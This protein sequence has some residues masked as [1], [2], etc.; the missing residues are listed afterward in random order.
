[1][2]TINIDTFAQLTRHEQEIVKR[3]N[4]MPNGGALFLIHP[5]QALADADV[6]LSAKAKDE[7]LKI[8]PRI[9]TLSAAPYRAMKASTSKQSYRIRI[10]GLFRHPKP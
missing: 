4:G 2:A 3:I 7:I 9:G 10:K 1:M 6:K 5:F 8:E